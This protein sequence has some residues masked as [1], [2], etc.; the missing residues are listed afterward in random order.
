MKIKRDKFVRTVNGV[1][2]VIYPEHEKK[3]IVEKL[4]RGELTMGEACEQYGISK[5]IT[6][7]RW[8]KRYSLMD[9]TAYTKPRVERFTR[10]EVVRQIEA[11]A[12]SVEEAMK[13][14]GIMSKITIKQWMREYSCTMET[15]QATLRATHSS[16]EESSQSSSQAMEGLKLRIAGLETLIDLAEKELGIDIRKKSGTKQ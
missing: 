13:R 1:Q 12:L 8:L 5:R 16:K 14:H 15:E 4:E 9:S 2:H 7:L 6:I 3:S 10:R 11:G